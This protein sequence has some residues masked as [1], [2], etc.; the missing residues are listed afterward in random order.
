MW[1]QTHYPS[2]TGGARPAIKSGELK[3]ESASFD[4]AKIRLYV[5]TAVATYRANVKAQFKGQEI[6]CP[7]QVTTT[8]VK[9]KGNWQVVAQS[10][11]IAG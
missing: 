6:T 11:R 1:E 4:A 9:T 3:Y 10:A 5:N 8:L 7:L 2:K